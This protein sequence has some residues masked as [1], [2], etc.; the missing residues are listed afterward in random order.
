MLWLRGYSVSCAPN[1]LIPR[2]LDVASIT[3]PPPE[4]RKNFQQ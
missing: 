2:R 1:P 4:I 3:V